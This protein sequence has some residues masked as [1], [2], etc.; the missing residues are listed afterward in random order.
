MENKK[1]TFLLIENLFST[2]Q[3]IGITRSYANK[4]EY[5]SEIRIKHDQRF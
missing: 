1:F 4:F 5:L 3:C 2:F